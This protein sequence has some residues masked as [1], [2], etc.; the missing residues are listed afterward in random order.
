M[1]SGATLDWRL[2]M[3]VMKRSLLFATLA[4]VFE[5]LAL[6]AANGPVRGSTGGH[7][8]ALPYAFYGVIVDDLSSEPRHYV[9]FL[10]SDDPRGCMTWQEQERRLRN[11]ATFNVRLAPGQQPLHGAGAFY[12]AGLTPSWFER[13]STR[14][15][16]DRIGLTI[17]VSENLPMTKKPNLDGEVEASIE[18]LAFEHTEG[19]IRGHF[20]ARHCAKMDDRVYE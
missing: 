15:T 6:A 4:V 11:R 2:A 18:V 19:S 8:A 3:R 10:L 5:L 17:P 1:P 20:V 16:L 9:S 13:E 12:T 7:T 14:V